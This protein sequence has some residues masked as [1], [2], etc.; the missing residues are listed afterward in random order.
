MGGA[1]DD[2][3]KK[4]PRPR[5]KKRA[6]D[7]GGFDYGAE[8]SP[9]VYQ[10]PPPPMGKG[11]GRGAGGAPGGAPGGL[12]GRKPPPPQAGNRAMSFPPPQKGGGRR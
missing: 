6:G 4:P 5:H 12:G 9:F 1:A 10:G 2:A 3:S 8:P 7:Y 11:G